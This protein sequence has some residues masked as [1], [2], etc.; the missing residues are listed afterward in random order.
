[1]FYTQPNDLLL[2]LPSPVPESWHAGDPAPID[3][4]DGAQER[5]GTPTASG[6]C[7][8]LTD[9]RQEMYI[10]KSWEPT[11]DPAT[12]DIGKDRRTENLSCNSLDKISCLQWESHET[13]RTPVILRR[14][15]I[16]FPV[17]WR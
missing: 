7:L 4:G 15:C 13:Q 12:I 16:E 3:G 11:E 9:L 5:P 14:D 10:D 1:M 8:G 6:S 17:Q 2:C